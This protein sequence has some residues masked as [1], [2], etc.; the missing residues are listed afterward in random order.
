MN[1]PV[2]GKKLAS[3]QLPKDCNSG[4]DP[5]TSS[6]AEVTW[7]SVATGQ[8]LFSLLGVQMAILPFE[9]RLQKH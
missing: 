2:L 1:R 4:V 5:A 3:S 8:A 7:K 6:G 9:F